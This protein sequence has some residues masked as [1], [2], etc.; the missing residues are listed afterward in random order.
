[1]NIVIIS[2]LGLGIIGFLAG[3]LLAYANQKFHVEEDPR[4]EAIEDALPGANCGACGYPGC[5]GFAEAVAAGKVD[6]AGCLLG[7]DETACKVAQI[8]G[9]EAA[10]GKAKT[11]A[12]LKCGGGKAESPARFDYK[13]VQ[14]CLAAHQIGGGFKACSYGCLGLGDCV[15]VCPVN[16]IKINVNGLPEVERSLCIA[17]GKCIEACPR[18]LFVL[19]PTTAEYH[20]NCSSKDKG[21]VVRKVC[22][23]GCIGCSIC[24]RKCPS[25]AITLKDF[26]AEI[27]Q[28]RCTKKAECIKACPTKCI[29]KLS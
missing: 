12:V 29:I 15:K 16:C 19:L 2:I 22:Q 9:V 20:V 4:V 10:G 21:P 7:G 5:R 13:G 17:C 23:V 24:V 8:M 26:L 6:V 27:Q 3:S 25:Q 18:N 28:Y 1:M 14:T 11:V